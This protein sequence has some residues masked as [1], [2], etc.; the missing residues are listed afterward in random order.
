MVSEP[1]CAFLVCWRFGWFHDPQRLQV[2]PVLQSTWAFDSTRG[3]I[4]ELRGFL[5]LIGLVGEHRSPTQL[6]IMD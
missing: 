1:I 5:E 3:A 2:S 4:P 6:D